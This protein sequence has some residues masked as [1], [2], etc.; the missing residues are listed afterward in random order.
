MPDGFVGPEDSLLEIIDILSLGV[1]GAGRQT[2]E[3]IDGV[4]HRSDG[5]VFALQQEDILLF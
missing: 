5:T 3:L 1:E 2:V 4:F